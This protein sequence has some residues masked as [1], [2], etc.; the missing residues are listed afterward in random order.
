[1]KWMLLFVFVGLA[2]AQPAVD[3]VRPPPGLECPR[4]QLTLY[5]GEVRHYQ[6]TGARTRITIAT[7]WG[8]METVTLP[9]AGRPD[10]S[11]WFLLRGQA[12]QPGDWALIESRLGVRRRPQCHRRLAAAAAAL[13]HQRGPRPPCFTCR[14]GRPRRPSPCGRPAPR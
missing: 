2:Q 5:G 12:F 11:A 3:R 7:D 4:D 9:H 14:S 8:T 13:R 10:A 6:R 1:M